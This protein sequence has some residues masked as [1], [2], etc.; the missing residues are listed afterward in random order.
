MTIA[1]R[2][3]AF[4]L[5][6]LSAGLVG[7]P[8]A[9]ADDTD[10][11]VS[12]EAAAAAPNV[13]FVFDTSGS[14]DTRVE[15][16]SNY[17]PAV[18]YEGACRS[19]RLYWRWESGSP[20]ACDTDRWIDAAALHCDAARAAFESGAGRLT[21]RFAQFDRNDAIW[22]SLGATADRSAVV[23][24]EDD[25]GRHGEHA[26][27]D[28]VYPQD[29]VAAAPW[30]SRPE[31]QIN[32]STRRLGTL[33]SAN[34]L[35]WYYG[36]TRDSTRMQVM[37][38]VARGIVGSVNGVNI[39][40]MRY[41]AFNGGTL[42]HEVADVAEHRQSLLAA[43]DSLTPSGFSPMAE[44]LYEATLY[45]L[46]RAPHFNEGD[47]GVVDGLYRS[48]ITLACQKNHIVYLTD[49]DPSRDRGV[50]GVVS[51]L[52]GFAEVAASG[53]S[54]SGDG[55][56]LEELARYLYETDL[57][58]SLPGKQNVAT[59][60]IG[61]TVDMPLL[62]RAAAA[63]G[64]EYYTADDTASLAQV[65]T[66][67]VTSILE[68]QATFVTPTIAVNAFNQ[69]RH[70][71]DLYVTVFQ[72]S[73]HLHWPGNL[74]KYRLR[75]ADG[76]IVDA[77]GRPAVGDDGFFLPSSQ[78]EWSSAVDGRSVT[79]GGAASRL[80]APDQRRIYTHLS[81]ANLTA[82]GNV[83]HRDNALLTDAVL[84][85][86]DPDDPSREEVID[87][88]R[89]AHGAAGG[90]S[91]TG[92]RGRIGDPLHSAPVFVSYRSAPAE[93]G[94]EQALLFFATNDGFLH[95][96]DPST[97]VEQWAFVPP[98][99]LADQAELLRNP[100]SPAK[101]YG[102][103]GN[104]KVQVLARRNGVIDPAAGDRV[105]L[106]FGLRRGGRSYYALDITAPDTPRLLW[107]RDATDLPG[108]GQTWSSPVPTRINVDGAIRPVVVFAGGYDETQDNHAAST[109]AHGN[110]LYIVDS[111]S[112]ALLWHGG[113]KG[114]TRN[115]EAMRYSMPADVK[116]IDLDGD[117]LADRI[118]AGDMG[119][120]VW[121][122]DI[123]NGQP[124]SSLVTGGVI[125]R[126]GAAAAPSPSAAETRRFYYAPDVAL[127]T[128]GGER[129]LHIG[130]GSGYRAHP[131][132]TAHHDRF[133]ALRDHDPFRH[134]S[135]AEFTSRRIVTEEDLIDVT[136]TH[137]AIIKPGSAGWM[138]RLAH[139][140]KVLAEA[141]T[142]AGDVYFTTFT[143][144]PP[145]AH[146][147]CE[148]RLGTNQLYVLRL[149]DGAP[150]NVF[151]RRIDDDPLG[152]DGG[153]GEATLSAT[154]SAP[155]AGSIGSGVSLLFPS[156]DDPESCVGDECAPLPMVCVDLFCRPAGF[157]NAPIRTFWRQE[158]VD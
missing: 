68:T 8:S 122:F 132:S 97:G 72:P 7:G 103:D 151:D 33:Y 12:R 120:Q 121:R 124:A 85:L 37:K 63:G 9:L 66:N 93:P 98:E 61:F 109:D 119:G 158:S 111:E 74:K 60:T 82:S 118:Y 106:F 156:P 88:I 6:L 19:D 16:Q 41:N 59:Y 150:A 144:A 22:K 47:V 107:R 77:H 148:P 91:G 3:A 57:D 14:M 75:A 62:A 123:F 76:A 21:N 23:E 137:D 51:A 134:L 126:L 136:D 35:N 135:Q 26:G 146:D 52:P 83:I 40:V 84:A 113:L 50:P 18:V 65:L 39:G 110:A 130:I 153:S 31:V 55:A 114:A 99:F 13:L 147:D 129:F 112:G 108:L 100:V 44:T 64:G 131:N 116:V 155:F 67:I 48:P 34:Y 20:P 143:P 115:F 152:E 15:T 46:G 69:T 42:L 2:C 10:I 45:F 53:C 1:N 32:W 102:I 78:S 24:C 80:P 73:N 142:F 89:G 133:Y 25:A 154:R 38:D 27:G 28:P 149:L 138:L 92:T 90:E 127:A 81:G 125:A 86:G 54:E 117:G 145:A 79:L 58:P 105:Y 70:T 157:G 30:S 71:N 17:D 140:E 87:F 94:S 11:F 139:G 43:V 5:G 96:L 56:C 141:R 4:A 36:P 49:G 29:G 101:H 104:L 95:A 128:A